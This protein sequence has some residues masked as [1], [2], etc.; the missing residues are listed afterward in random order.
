[1]KTTSL[2]LITLS[3]GAQASEDIKAPKK[4]HVETRELTSDKSSIAKNERAIAFDAAPT[5]QT[6]ISISENGQKEHQCDQLDMNHVHNL[7]NQGEQ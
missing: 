5:Y 6:S 1:M 7:H 3:F 2:L 4:I